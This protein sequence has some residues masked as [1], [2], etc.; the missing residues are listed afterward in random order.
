LEPTGETP[1]I[2]FDNAYEITALTRPEVQ[3]LARWRRRIDPATMAEIEDFIDNL[4]DR[5]DIRNTTWDASAFLGQPPANAIYATLQD[6]PTAACCWGILVKNGVINREH[7]TDERWGRK[8]MEQED[9]ESNV[10]ES[11][12]YFRLG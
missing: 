7:R 11:R 9:S 8:T 12:V 1:I 2:D 3:D 5:S 10:R 4:L 6:E